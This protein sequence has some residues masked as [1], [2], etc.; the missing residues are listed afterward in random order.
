MN[1]QRNRSLAFQTWYLAF[2]CTRIYDEVEAF[3]H[4]RNCT[5]I[6]DEVEASVLT[7]DCT[8]LKH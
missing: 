3:V 5:S 4:N 8:E 2:Q 6:H 1:I 7:R